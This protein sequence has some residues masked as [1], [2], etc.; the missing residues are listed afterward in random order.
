VLPLQYS[1]NKYEF[2]FS[3]PWGELKQEAF[4]AV[5]NKNVF[6]YRARTIKSGDVLEIEIFPI[7]NTQ[8]E[9]RA[10]RKN[11]TR[12]AQVDL[13]ERNAKKSLI[14]KVNSN[15]TDQDYHATLT[16]SGGVVPDEKQARRDMQNYIKRVRYYH[17]S[18]DL[19]PIKYIYVIE[20]STG[21]GRRSRVH[22]H[23]IINGGA[24]RQVLKDL[25]KHGRVRVDELEPE[26]GTLEGLARYITKQPG[27]LIQSKRWACSRNLKPY[28]K[29]TE[30]DHKISK[31]Q[32]E[33]LAADMTNA[34][35]AIFGKLFKDYTFDTCDVKG[36]EY[37]SGAYIYAKM[38]KT[39]NWKGARK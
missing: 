6:R 1:A 13:N 23:V 16:Y 10:A 21:D 22:H 9:V 39:Q 25:W 38:Y 7:W 35:P 31:R 29:K 34:A 24:D 20:F 26:D 32:A 28:D 18:R 37:V 36:S 27:K 17:K 15:F 30:S 14:R 5:R 33:T 4:E 8:N 12:A 3:Q 11:T 19:P 2:L